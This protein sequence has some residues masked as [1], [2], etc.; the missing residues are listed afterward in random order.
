MPL[1]PGGGIPETIPV[2]EVLVN[3]VQRCDDMVGK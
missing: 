3:L 2:E 1:P